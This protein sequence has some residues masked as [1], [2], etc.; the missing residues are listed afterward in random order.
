MQHEGRD[1]HR[2]QHVPDVDLLVHQVEGLE[3]AG[4][5]AVAQI[6]E[7]RLHLVVLEYPERP[8]GLPAFL[9]GPVHAQRPFDIA[10]VLLLGSA[11]GVVGKPDGAGEGAPE[12]ERGRSLRVGRREQDAHRGALGDAV[13]RSALRADRVHDGAHVVHASLQRG[14][15]AH[16]VGHARPALVK[17]DQ[18]GE[19]RE[20]EEQRPEQRQPPRELDMRDKPRN[21]NEVQGP[22]A[23]DLVGDV[24]VAAA[25]I[26]RLGEIRHRANHLSPLPARGET[27]ALR[28][29]PWGLRRGRCAHAHL[30]SPCRALFGL[31]DGGSPPAE[32]AAQPLGRVAPE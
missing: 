21:E 3:R 2:R 29:A 8:H 25:R 1:A 30:A 7:E 28:A 31:G 24:D 32:P 12:H 23:H 9:A 14:R 6:V 5:G 10:L 26:A 22:V 18:T 15:S 11:P 17:A 13:E 27:A 19:R 4:A 16:G 20:P